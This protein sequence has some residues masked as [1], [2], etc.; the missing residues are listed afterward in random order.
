MK[1]LFALVALVLGVVSCQKDHAGMDVNMGGEQEVLI[2]VSLPEETR[3]NSAV[4]DITNLVDSD[5]Y[6][7]RYI[8]Q[9]YNAEGKVS[10][11]PVYHYTDAKTASFPVRLVPGRD[12]RFVV[13]ADIVNQNTKAD[14]HYITTAFPEISLNTTW[15]A[16]DETRDA[17]TVS[18]VVEE[19]N[20]AKSISLTLKRPLAKLRVITTDMKE[21]LGLTPES[22]TVS[23]ISKH[24][25][26][27]N[28]LS[29]KFA[30]EISAAHTY[31]IAAYEDNTETDKVLFTDYFFA[32]N[33]VVNFSMIVN[34]SDGANVE[35]SFTTDIP[36]K[37]NF[38]TTIKGDILTDGN[39][40]VVNVEEGFDG[41]I[42]ETL[43]GETTATVNNAED[44][45]EAVNNENI[46]NI[47]LGNDIDLDELL[48]ASTLS[49]RAGATLP[50]VIANGKTL[51]LDLNGFKI[52]TPFVE[53]STTNH[54]Y[55]FENR[56]TLTIQDS[57]GN[58]EIKARGIFN[59]GTMTLK[60]GTINACDG[61]G[62]YGVRN[63][64]GEFVMD[65]GSIITSYEDGDKPVEGYDAS[66]VR[67]DEDATATINGGTINNV[68]N[69]TFAIDNYGTTTI[70]DGTFTTIHTTI[71]N[72]STMTI[73][74]GSFTCN[75]L[76][77]ISAHALWAEAGTTTINGG[78]FDGKDNY[79]GF[80][81]DAEKGAVVNINGGEFL[82]VHSGSLYGQ[83]TINVMGGRFFDDPS[84]RV[85]EGYKVE[86]DG[87]WFEVKYDPYYGYTKVASA[88]EL[89]AA[90]NNATTNTN[91]VFLND[92]VGDVTIDNDAVKITIHG[93]GKTYTG[94]MTPKSNV[95]FKNVNFDGKGY[96]G[97]AIT[98]R[99]ANYLTIEDCTAK[100]YGYGFV[101]LASA[102]DLTTVKNVTVSDMNYGI[103]VDY[104]NA[105]V[106][107]NAN[108][109]VGVAAVL[110][111]NYGGKT[112]TIKNSKLS[113]L[114][115]WVRNNTIKTNY[116]FEGNNSINTFIIEAA[117]DNFKLAA[118]ATLTAPNEITVT[119][120]DGYSVE[121][122]DGKYISK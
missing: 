45:F 37:R 62:G 48:G 96:N 34:M 18:E 3:A 93:D 9:V 31:S 103:K 109:N 112:I 40:I 72:H 63:Y 8:F 20:S 98:T 84:K 23:Y 97:Y 89:V 46:E 73:N 17:Y 118:G 105:V 39:N 113:I 104:S 52:T 121:Y 57:K 111:S 19:F 66:P 82:P 33:K 99:G 107:E 53:G 100:N 21:L 54:F 5:D 61:N 80:N 15:A 1:K 28:A 115:T 90:I 58:G 102:T 59:Y 44:F 64:E 85:A 114:G 27:F 30:G 56:G 117:L 4:S 81:I 11:D 95:T 79:N 101:Q 91:I 55:A 116:L 88:D 14:L 25:N 120:V 36:V 35:R 22:A 2:N 49:T 65:G 26:A 13:W 122:T 7:I 29:S 77:G 60:S 75:G 6:T 12:Y 51:T 43:E 94:A 50:I 83:G 119:T 32:D 67:V 42:D 38:L 110:N 10:K 70:N 108:I 87:D 76:E 71:A 86:T 69:Y 78:T 41:A 74:G 16:M 24:Y 47:V 92:I 106:I 68:S